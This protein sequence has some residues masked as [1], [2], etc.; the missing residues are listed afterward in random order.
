MNDNDNFEEKVANGEI[1]LLGIEQICER[2]TV[3]RTT[4]IRIRS[5]ADPVDPKKMYFP[6]PDTMIGRSPKWTVDSLN[7]W[8]AKVIDYNKRNII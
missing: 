2:L 3:S 5:A 4:F 6:P 1:V 8:I 7:N